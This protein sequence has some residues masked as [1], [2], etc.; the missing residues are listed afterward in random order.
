MIVK[1]ILIFAWQN[2]TLLFLFLV[3][4][5]ISGIFQQ[6]SYGLEEDILATGSDM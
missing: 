2:Q 6:T 3:T 5:Y 4:F 1:D